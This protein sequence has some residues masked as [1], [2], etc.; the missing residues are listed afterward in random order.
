[1]DS[2]N[3]QIKIIQKV[4]SSWSRKNGYS[5]IYIKRIN[6]AKRDYSK[7]AL[8]GKTGRTKNFSLAPVK[9]C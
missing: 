8:S 1:M 9:I 4:P 3:Y 2:K 6:V 7:M 5:L